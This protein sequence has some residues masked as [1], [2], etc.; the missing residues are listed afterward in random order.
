[1]H[2]LLTMLR[3]QHWLVASVLVLSHMCHA[4]VGRYKPTEPTAW[5]ASFSVMLQTNISWGTTSDTNPIGPNLDPSNDTTP[6]LTLHSGGKLFYE[7][8]LNAQRVDHDAGSV[9]CVKFYHTN[10][11][12]SLIS[13][14]NG[15]YRTI[16]DPSPTSPACC[17]D[18]P[19]IPSLP[20]NWDQMGDVTYEGAP[21]PSR[22]RIR[23]VVHL[24]LY[25]FDH[26]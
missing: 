14:R 15:T 4:E 18:M 17:L 22:I 1:M 8:G 3:A 21:I 2:K 10:V 9:E 20:P 16:V 7:A 5:P 6:I 26:I 24:S 13:N 23:T 11:S 25:Q 12:C 19:M